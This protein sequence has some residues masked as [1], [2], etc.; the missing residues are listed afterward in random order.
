MEAAQAPRPVSPATSRPVV[1]TAIA[2]TFF[3]A[4][5]LQIIAALSGWP[6]GSFG[7]ARWLNWPLY[8]AAAPFAGWLLWKGRS[9]AR[10]A[11]YIFLTTEALRSVRAL[12]RHDPAPV[13]W[14][15]LAV[16]VALILMLQ[17]PAARRF[18]PSLRPAEI[19]ARLRRRV[20]PDTGSLTVPKR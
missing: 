7:T 16:V 15:T 5:A 10:F 9:R 1:I 14:A 6:I 3:A 13:P 12:M 2:A 8:L 11:T 19:R 20:K 4:P 18:C 17:L